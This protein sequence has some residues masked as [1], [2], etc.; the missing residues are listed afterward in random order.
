LAEEGE[1]YLDA[2]S[3]RGQPFGFSEQWFILGVVDEASLAELRAEWARG[4]DDNPEHYRWRAFKQFLAAHRPLTA[5]SAAQIYELGAADPDQLMGSAMM[6]DIVALPECPS[7]VRER[8]RASGH[9]FLAK[10]VAR[11]EKLEELACGLT[12]DLFE[13]CL[14]E[15]D[16]EIHLQLVGMDGLTRDQVERLAEVGASR[17]IRNQA[18]VRLRGGRYLN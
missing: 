11:V 15:R 13:R 16:K 12:V 5:E 8:A 9:Q 7:A 17:A 18:K 3:E 1:E 2:I 14:A 10:L 6:A 4:E